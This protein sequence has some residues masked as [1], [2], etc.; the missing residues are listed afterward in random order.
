MSRPGLETLLG[1]FPVKRFLSE[2]WP[3]T[4]LVQHGPVERFAGWL[5]LP[6]SSP[7]A[8]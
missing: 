4:M 3:S 7:S 8:R 5:M 1:R 2:H 6:S